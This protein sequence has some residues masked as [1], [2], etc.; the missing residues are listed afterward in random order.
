MKS[1]SGAVEQR[2]QDR[3]GDQRRGDLDR[4]GGRVGRAAD[5]GGDVGDRGGGE[6]GEDRGLAAAP[7]A[8]RSRRAAGRGRR[9]R[10]GSSRRPAP[11][12]RR[13]PGGSRR[14][15]DPQRLEGRDLA[16]EVAEA[17]AVG[18]EGLEAVEVD[19]PPD[20]G[21][22]QDER[23]RRTASSDRAPAAAGPRCCIADAA[24]PGPDD[25]G[26]E[27]PDQAG[28]AVG[29]DGADR[30][31]G[32]RDEAEGEIAPAPGRLSSARAKARRKRACIVSLKSPWAK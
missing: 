26:A 13:G 24:P 20:L 27:Q 12:R 22:D 23:R 29:V 17:G 19:H 10:R 1:T 18:V 14:G 3:Q 30:Q 2:Q 25:R 11:R 28:E 21:G 8:H 6:A 9:R 32:G 31:Q 5:A 7:A 15:P 4:L 16:E